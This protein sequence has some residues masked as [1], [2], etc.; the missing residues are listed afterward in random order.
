MRRSSRIAVA[1]AALLLL[2]VYVAPLWRIELIA[3]Q[4]P[5]GSGCGSG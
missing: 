5:K 2:A 3:P 4:Y 1:V